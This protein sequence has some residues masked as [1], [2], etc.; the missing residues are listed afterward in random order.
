MSN[1]HLKWIIENEKWKIINGAKK[2][3]PII[4][5]QKYVQDKTYFI[6]KKVGYNFCTINF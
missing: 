5:N 6:K 3:H 1:R 2:L 4:A